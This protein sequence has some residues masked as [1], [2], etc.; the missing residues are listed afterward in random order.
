M[1]S[2]CPLCGAFI[3]ASPRTQI[4]ALAERLHRCYPWTAQAMRDRHA[5]GPGLAGR[6]L[7]TPQTKNEADIPWQS[8][9]GSLMRKLSQREPALKAWLRHSETNARLFRKD[10]IAALRAANLGLEEELLHELERATNTAGQRP[11]PGQ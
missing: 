3:A 11:K 7:A 2:Y 8:R 5:A 9:M 1:E 10:P 4:L 6:T